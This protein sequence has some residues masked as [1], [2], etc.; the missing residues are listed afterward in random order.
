MLKLLRMCSCQHGLFSSSWVIFFFMFKLISYNV[1]GFNLE[2]KR[3]NL[4][5]K[6]MPTVLLLQESKLNQCSSNVIKYLWGNESFDWRGIYTYG[7]SGGIIMIWD[8]DILD[9]LDSI[10]G[11]FSLN[12]MFSNKSD[13][14]KWT[15]SNV[16]SSWLRALKEGD[17]NTDYFHRV[18]NGRKRKIEFL[19]Y[20][21]MTGWQWRRRR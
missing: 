18:E 19:D 17:R 8:S 16:Y 7:R 21:L 9:Y 1:N 3:R 10:E 5:T 11:A 14:F 12:C 15:L 2:S 6:W 20:A 13:E 4:R